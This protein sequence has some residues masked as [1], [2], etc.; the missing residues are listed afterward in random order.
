MK[1]QETNQKSL[2]I[3]KAI[4]LLIN[5]QDGIY[6]DCT[7]GNGGHSK[8]ILK[9]LSKKGKLI[10]IDND[11]NTKIYAKKIHDKRFKL[12]NINF[13]KLENFAFKKK[14]GKVSGI[15]LD[16]GISKNQIKDFKRGFSFYKN[17]P[18]D[19]RI[20]NN[21][22]IKASEMLNNYKKKEILN[23]LKKYGEDKK[24][25]KITN[26]ICKRR[27]KYPFKMTLEL[28]N[29]IKKIKFKKNKTH[30]ATK[31]FQSIRIY[32]NNELTNLEKVIISSLDLLD[33]NKKLIIITF[34][35]LES[36]LIKSLIKTNTINKKKYNLKKIYPN[37]EELIFNKSSRSATM[38][39]I[40]KS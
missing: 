8:K 18:L 29:L 11:F 7:Y 5:N 33:I 25:N 40:K 21:L 28:S 17:G 24:S 26:E 4:D 22:G 14:L 15:L 34:N 30:P 19:M 9:R 27:I 39:V 35:S 36:T 12:I 2:F 38:Y 1:N 37:K 3:N 6:I 32:I 16:L 10:A 20:N 13:N 31:V 23:I